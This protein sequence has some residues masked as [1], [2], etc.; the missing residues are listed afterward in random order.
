M[1]GCSCVRLLQ[2]WWQTKPNSE[3]MNNWKRFFGG[4]K[5]I[6]V[7]AQIMRNEKFVS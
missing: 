3:L 2:N 5:Q 1:K 6:Y 4:G 7:L